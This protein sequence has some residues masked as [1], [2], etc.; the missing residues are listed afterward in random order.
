MK[1]HILLILFFMNLWMIVLNLP[2]PAQEIKN[3]KPAVQKAD[4]TRTK[5]IDLEKKRKQLKIFLDKIEILGRVEKPQTVFILPGNDP[6]V[7]DITIDRSF[8]KQIFR[9]VEKDE[10]P[11]KESQIKKV[12]VIW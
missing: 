2:L 12:P 9:P 4:S 6:T 7:D 11:H 3:Q 1:N 10:F 8:F 5:P